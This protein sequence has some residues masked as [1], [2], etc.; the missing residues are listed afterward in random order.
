MIKQM[1][2]PD[3][4]LVLITCEVT[5]LYH[6]RKTRRKAN[7]CRPVMVKYFIKA[8]NEEAGRTFIYIC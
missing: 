8:V 5:G 6:L 1:Y 2:L 4:K 7:L 3:V